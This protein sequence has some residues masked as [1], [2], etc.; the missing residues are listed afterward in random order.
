V[1]WG[2]GEMAPVSRHFKW[3]ASSIAPLK[4]AQY[5]RVAAIDT[6]I[7]VAMRAQREDGSKR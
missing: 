1:F 7:V 2:F 6:T 5:A 4:V 3:R